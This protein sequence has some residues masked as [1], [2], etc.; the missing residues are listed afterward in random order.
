MPSGEKASVKFSQDGAG[1]FILAGQ[2]GTVRSAL[3]PSTL[4]K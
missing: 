3:L 2:I 1:I 4:K